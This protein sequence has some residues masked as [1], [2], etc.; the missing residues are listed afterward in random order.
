MTNGLNPDSH[1]ALQGLPPNPCPTAALPSI[2][3][4]L[5]TCPHLFCP[6]GSAPFLNHSSLVPT[7]LLP[8]LPTLALL[9]DQDSGQLSPLQR[10]ASPEHP[11]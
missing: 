11:T 8:D 2:S 3:N 7:S 5:H 1:G 10:E 4:L 9:T 6:H